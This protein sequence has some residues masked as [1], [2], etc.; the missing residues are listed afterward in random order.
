VTQGELWGQASLPRAAARG[1]QVGFEKRRREHETTAAP[2]RM[3]GTSVNDLSLLDEIPDP[4]HEPAGQPLR[5]P[6]LPHE[7]TEQAPDRRQIR[8]RRRNACLLSGGWL[9]T[10]L[11]VFGLRRDLHQ[12]PSGYV[13]AQVWLPL[14]LALASLYV[15]TRPGRLGLGVNWAVIATLAV[16]GPLTF[17]ITGLATP[18]P[19]A[20]TA[21]TQPWLGALVC[22]DIMLAWMSAP[23][24]AAAFALRGAFAAAASWRS[25][26]VGAGVGLFSGVTINLHC[27]NVHPFHLAIGHGVPVVLGSLLGAFVVTRWVRS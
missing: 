13:L 20:A 15:A 19:Y 21:D 25:A 22:S 12:L 17:W 16:L 18:M 7:L 8:R 2:S 4:A 23:L 1:P 3:L 6:A 11:A 14:A 9:L 27:P 5:L 10:H 26:L 24:F